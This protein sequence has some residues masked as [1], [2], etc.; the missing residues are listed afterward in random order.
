MDTT[1]FTGLFLALILLG[2]AFWQFRVLVRRSAVIMAKRDRIEK[3]LF[4]FLHRQTTRRFQMCLL[5]SL[6]AVG[7]LVGLLIPPADYPRLFLF[8]W[9]GVL[10]L[11]VWGMFLAFVD[12]VA[13]RLHYSLEKQQNEAEK[14]GLEYVAKSLKKRANEPSDGTTTNVTDDASDDKSDDRSKNR[15]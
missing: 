2:F 13:V 4:A 3:D 1:Q 5:F 7:M 15:S 14:L 9:G 12:F 10:C 11:L 8:L 6:A